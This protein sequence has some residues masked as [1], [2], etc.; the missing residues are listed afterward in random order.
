MNEASKL[1]QQYDA[2]LLGA[3][4]STVTT[5]T[6]CYSLKTLVGLVMLERHCQAPEARQI[7]L[8]EMIKP[9]SGEI[10]FVDD[11]LLEEPPVVDES[12]KIYKP[13]QV[14]SRRWK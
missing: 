3:T 11:T 12:P 6:F 9:F 10:T 4:V 2:A 8:A 1:P 13:T 14:G 7:V 5:D